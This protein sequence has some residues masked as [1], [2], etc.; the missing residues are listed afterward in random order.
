MKYLTIGQIDATG[1]KGPHEK[2]LEDIVRNKITIFKNLDINKLSGFV[3]KNL[4]GKIKNIGLDED[5]TI[6]LRLFPEVNI[7]ILYFYYGNEFDDINAELKVLFSGERAYWIPGEDL[8]TYIEIIMYFLER[9]I[10]NKGTVD[11]EYNEKSDL[12]LKAFEQRKSLFKFLEKENIIELKS[13]LGADIKKSNTEWKFKKEIFLEIFIKIIFSIN[14][15]KLDISYSGKNLKKIE[16]YHIELIVIFIINHIL[17][18]VTINN[19]GKE[20]PN[21]CYMMFSRLFTKEK[22]WDYR[23]LS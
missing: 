23:N 20:L 15:D 22:G 13:F 2:E 5:W 11:Q 12:L 14:E 16:K 6:T 21:I 17:R 19:Q 8:A 18:F 3:N 1:I 9:N 7:N 4:G 10:K